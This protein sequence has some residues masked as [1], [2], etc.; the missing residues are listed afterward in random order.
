MIAWRQGPGT[1]WLSNSF[2]NNLSNETML[3]IA[4]STRVMR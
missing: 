1:Y 4:E 3:A 2:L